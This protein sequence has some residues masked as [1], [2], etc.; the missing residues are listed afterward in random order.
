MDRRRDLVAR[1]PPGF[2]RCAGIRTARWRAGSAPAADL[3]EWLGY[4]VE[5]GCSGILLGPIFAAETHGY[6]TVDH[7]RIDSRLGDGEDFD[8]LVAAAGQ[9]RTAA[10]RAGDSTRPTRS[11]RRAS[12]TSGQHR[13][14]RARPGRHF[15]EL[16]AAVGQRHNTP[17]RRYEHWVHEGGIATP[18]IASW[19]GTIPAGVINHGPAHIVDL[20]ATCLDLANATYP[21]V[22]H[23]LSGS[24]RSRR[25]R[26]R[27]TRRSRFAACAA[28]SWGP[29]SDESRRVAASLLR[30]QGH[31]DGR[32]FDLARIAP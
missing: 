18:F 6:D 14:P 11:P 17:F 27:R 8:R 7:F 9:R 23:L 21:R 13:R 24:P 4:A 20:M 16:R 22:F 15:H 31:P 10:R 5:L 12:G 1:V 26:P 3:E 25:P 2:H 32:G 19:P 30:T 28:L 29:H